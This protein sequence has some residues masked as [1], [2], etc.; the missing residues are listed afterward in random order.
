[1]EGATALARPVDLLAFLRRA[2]PAWVRVHDRRDIEVARLRRRL[3]E[4]HTRLAGQRHGGVRAVVHVERETEVLHQIADRE[5]RRLVRATHESRLARFEGGRETGQRPEDL[6]AIQTRGRSRC[7]QLGGSR[8]GDGEH[9]VRDELQPGR[10]PE[11]ADVMNLAETLQD[12]PGLREIVLRAAHE[13]GERPALDGGDAADDRR[14]EQAQPPCPGLLAEL[15]DALRSGGAHVD[16]EGRFARC[17]E[18]PARSEVHLANG[19]RV[20]QAANGD[21]GVADRHGRRRRHASDAQR[22]GLRGRSVPHRDVGSSRCEPPRDRTAH[23]ARAED[24]DLRHGIA[25][26]AG[27][28]ISTAFARSASISSRSDAPRR[29]WA[30]AAGSSRCWGWRA[31]TIA[32]S[33]AG[34]EMAQAIASCGSVMSRAAAYCL[35]RSTTSRSLANRSPLKSLLLPR[36]SSAANVVCGVIVPESRPCAS[37]PYTRIPMS[38]FVAYGR[39]SASMSRWNMWYSGWSLSTGPYA[40]S[41]VICCGL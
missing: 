19:A 36:Q 26:G 37:G 25:S 41:S 9:R 28:T 32:T 29:M 8:A 1:M 30:A 31:P 3:C 35:S 34:L 24:R 33:T 11:A 6:L 14:L 17:L 23:A 20:R 22:L 2:V 7:E 5:H 39:I 16:E 38:F 12:G 21:I 13:H 4:Q 15:L 18:S 40:A 10:A 27:P